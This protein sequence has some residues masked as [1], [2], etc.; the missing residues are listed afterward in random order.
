MMTAIDAPRLLGIE[1]AAQMLGVGRSPVYDL[2]RTRRLRTVK[3]GRRRLV[4]VDAIG[5]AVAQLAEGT[6]YPRKDGRWETALYVTTPDGTRRRKRL[7]GKTRAEV[8]TKLAALTART[9]S[10]IPVPVRSAKLG[11]YLDHWLAEVVGHRAETTRRGYESAVRL[12]IRPLLG[13]RPLDKLSTADVRR[14]LTAVR[15]KCL[16]C[17][18]GLDRRRPLDRQCC[19]RQRC[20]KKVPSVRQV[21]FVHAVLRNALSNAVREE[22]LTRNVAKLV[23][24]PTPRYRVGKGLA[25]ADVKRL[26]AE[27]EGHRLHPLYLMAATMGLR[28]GE[29]LGL[30]WY[31]LDLERGT[32]R[33]TWNVQ[34]VGDRLLM[35]ETKSLDSDRVVPLPQVTRRALREHEK[36]HAKEREAAG[37]YWTD[38][39]LAFPTAV[40]TPMEPRI[41]NRHFAALRVRAGLDG[42]RL[43]DLRHSMITFLLELGVPP[44]IVQAIAGH[45]D[46]DVTMRIYAHANLDAMRDAMDRLDDHPD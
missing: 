39:G 33:V 34:R 38:H 36:V 2:I 42:I 44:H 23:P 26:L 5:E 37:R 27:A 15:S 28:R 31:D 43:H 3:I 41:L 30:H 1:V 29:L 19:S 45:A 18:N 22:L 20:C 40:G 6:I 12:H 25:A 13:T 32:L 11:D 16:C 46:V 8:V 35:K 24:V 7:Y 9:A 14:L 4:P 17:A 10:G 21:Q